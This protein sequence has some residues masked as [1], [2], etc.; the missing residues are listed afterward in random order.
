MVLSKRELI[1]VVRQPDGILI[2][3][4]GKSAGRGAYLHN[5]RSC[6]ERA[7]KGPLAHA[8]KIELTAQDRERLKAFL[9]TLPEDTPEE[10]EEV[11]SV[12][13]S[14]KASSQASAG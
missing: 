10:R 5:R 4:S 7:L 1:R 9:I 6:W 12:E 2:D 11:S 8:L 3:P 14:A 13:T